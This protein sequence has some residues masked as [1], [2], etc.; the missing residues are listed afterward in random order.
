MNLRFLLLL[1][2]CIAYLTAPETEESLSVRAY[3]SFSLKEFHRGKSIS[4]RIGALGLM[5]AK[6]E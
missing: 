2:I 4:F 6:K 1:S 3:F 5:S